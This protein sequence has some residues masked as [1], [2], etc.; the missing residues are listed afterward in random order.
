VLLR[1]LWIAQH[2]GSRA[3]RV[4]TKF[5]SVDFGAAKCMDVI[6]EKHCRII[7]T[8]VINFLF[9]SPLHAQSWL[10]ADAR[11]RALPIRKASIDSS[12]GCAKLVMDCIPV[13]IWVA[14]R[15]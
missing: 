11:R 15:S 2:N 1:T 12:G 6:S 3:Q 13:V 9:S 5:I 8:D 10:F 7:E 4:K 14:C